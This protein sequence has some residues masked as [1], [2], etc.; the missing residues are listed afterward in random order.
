MAV[1][2]D[3]FTEQVQADSVEKEP[4]PDTRTE[5]GQE[6]A[7]A[8]ARDQESVTG[9]EYPEQIHVHSGGDGPKVEVVSRRSAPRPKPEAAATPEQND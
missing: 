9:S 1:W 6:M 5:I 7:A 4:T 3:K 2:T 8:S